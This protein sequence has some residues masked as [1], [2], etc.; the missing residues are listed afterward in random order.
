[1][2]LDQIT[3]QTLERITGTQERWRRRLKGLP[4]DWVRAHRYLGPGQSFAAKGEAVRYDFGL[5]P[6]AEEALD[7]L[8]HPD[9]QMSVWQWAS[10]L[11]KTE[12]A[13]NLIG[14]KIDED[15]TKILVLY[16]IDR[17][18][19]TWAKESLEP[20][21]EHSPTLRGRVAEKRSHDSKNTISN[22]LFPG[23]S[24]SVIAGGSKKQLSTETRRSRHR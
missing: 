3:K 10:D 14:Y 5:T 16:P 22:K 13:L 21:I 7:D 2:I 11:G 19:R 15:P 8:V 4:S 23:G 9:V 18:A 20:M 6:Y 24:I 12:T 1:M 17:S